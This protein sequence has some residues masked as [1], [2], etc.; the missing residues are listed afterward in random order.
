MH[1]PDTPTNPD[2]AGA[3]PDDTTEPTGA[4][5][6]ADADTNPDTETPTPETPEAGTETPEGEGDA[7]SSPLS[8]IA[9]A[10]REKA[11]RFL[12]MLRGERLPE[13]DDTEMSKT[14]MAKRGAK[15]GISVLATLGGYKGAWDGPAWFYQKFFT[16]PAERKRIKEALEEGIDE[17]DTASSPLEQ[18]QLQI[19][20][21]IESSKF[22]SAEKK[23]KLFTKLRDAMTTHEGELVALDEERN[24]AI[25][26][27]LDEYI[28]TR[29]KGTVA[30][31]ESVNTAL[32]AAADATGLGV[33]MR[34]ARAGT[35][36]AVSLY[37]R[38]DRVS[39]ERETGERTEGQLKEFMKGFGETWDKLWLKGEGTKKEKAL[40]FM[41]AAGTVGRFLGMGA[42][43]VEAG[44]DTEAGQEFLN[45][46]LDNFAGDSLP[47]AETAVGPLPVEAPGGEVGAEAIT[48]EAGG[49]APG[50]ETAASSIETGEAG[51]SLEDAAEY[52]EVGPIEFET[53][54]IELGTVRTGDG[55]LKTLERQMEAA[56]QNFGY[57]GDLTD[58]KAIDAWAKSTAMEAAR[59][60][61][62][63]YAGGDVRLAEKAIDNLAVMA[64]P[65]AEGGISIVLINNETGNHLSLEDAKAQGFTYES[66]AYGGGSKETE[67][68]I[69][70]LDQLKAESDEPTPLDFEPTPD[71]PHSLVGGAIRFEVGPGGE[72]EFNRVID[73]EWFSEN[74]ST[75]E[76]MIDTGVF[77][78]SVPGAMERVTDSTQRLAGYKKI[79]IVLEKKGLSDSAEADFLRRRIALD[80]KTLDIYA[81]N[82]LNEENLSDL[83][84]LSADVDLSTPFT[85]QVESSNQ[86][87][88][89]HVPGIGKVAFEYSPD[90]TPS[91]DWQNLQ[92]EIGPGLRRQAKDLLT[93]GWED[94]FGEA[95]VGFLTEQAAQ[96]VAAELFL[97]NQ[98]LSELVSAGHENSPEAEFL[99]L[100]IKADLLGNAGILNEDNPVIKS[101]RILAGLE[102]AV[103]APPV[104]EV[105]EP[106]RVFTEELS[107]EDEEELRVEEPAREAPRPPAPEITE[108]AE[109]TS[110]GLE[111]AP[112]GNMKFDIKGKGDIRFTYDDK[113]NVS[114]MFVPGKWITNRELM[115]DALAQDGMTKRSVEAAFSDK[116]GGLGP[117]VDGAPVDRGAPDY[118]ETDISHIGNTAQDE[119]REFIRKTTRLY[120]QERALDE[121]RTAGLAGTPEF[122]KLQEETEKLRELAEEAA[123]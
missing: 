36:G 54:Q 82:F 87:D 120:V 94:D 25:A 24:E 52:T 50:L 45:S 22:L 103:A 117:M 84:D 23:E 2:D 77:E 91:M 17:E 27:L 43:G 33:A 16:N 9:D 42:I 11:N 122:A 57:E 40:G 116:R 67:E 70:R 111:K 5:T 81:P 109:G 123:P 8:R 96:S 4:D 47:E 14:E 113:G 118:A 13:E 83:E 61:G 80:L 71:V 56:P 121:M 49:E 63:V 107:F 78:E 93:K 69:A 72:L 58:A 95:R 79:L 12:T 65:T 110:K 59:E 1:N 119:A 108:A 86:I 114:G 3:N 75:L 51:S 28:T 74:T 62:V 31:K 53:P 85:E 112:F 64:K 60:S 15:V 66:G 106:F 105:A 48:A 39:Q 115:K 20:A 92:D 32:H 89:I 38:W 29:V 99:R 68:T 73:P 7:E 34:L 104:T 44:L 26:Q 35:Y 21:A 101:A 90:G 76:G 102:P 100:A 19:R 41:S 88:T 30:L 18:K 10:F 98:A 37:E 6:G 46:M 97:K 55:I